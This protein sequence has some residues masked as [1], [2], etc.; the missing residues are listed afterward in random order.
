MTKYKKWSKKLNL[1]KLRR[2]KLNWMKLTLSINSDSNKAC[3]SPREKFKG[4]KS[5]NLKVA[6]LKM[7]KEDKS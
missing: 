5:L 2:R 6:S 3:L 1:L 7:I 4:P